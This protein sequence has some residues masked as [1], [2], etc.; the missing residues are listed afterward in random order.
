MA[1]VHFVGVGGDPPEMKT[2]GEIIIELSVHSHKVD[3]LASSHP[4]AEKAR[5]R[6]GGWRVP[7]MLRGG[8]TSL[9]GLLSHVRLCAGIATQE[10]SKRACGNVIGVKK[11][12]FR[13]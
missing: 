8:A 7:Q 10:L 5:G 13:F 2:S 9:S 3:I 12:M 4:R 1:F 11:K 6:S